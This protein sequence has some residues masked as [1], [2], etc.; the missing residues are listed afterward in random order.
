MHGSTVGDERL[1]GTQRRPHR[2]HH[3]S[4]FED[5]LEIGR[6][7]RAA[8]YDLTPGPKR[9]LVPPALCF[10]VEERILADGSIEAAPH[11]IPVQRLA[12]RLREEGVES[13]A[14]CLLHSYRQP[15]SEQAVAGLL[16]QVG[17][18][19]VSSE[20]CPEFREYE[21]AC[22]TALNAYVGPV[23][24]RYLQE[25]ESSCG[26]RIWI[27]QSNGGALTIGEA[28]RQAVRTILSGPAGGVD[29]RSGD[30]KKVGLLPHH[31]I[32]HGRHLHRRLPL[33]RT[34]RET[35]EAYVDGLPVR[36]PMLEIH[37]VGAGGGC[38]RDSTR[39]ASSA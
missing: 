14:I 35:H 16:R 11:K 18:L 3:H 32:R 17:F 24:Q 13:V 31:R 26:G 19:S 39:E 4:R 15:A 2:F 8:L 7:N 21:R 27:M 22:T 20:V 9:L 36:V 6:Q 28:T 33:R 25:L 30:R 10:G 5:L 37:T 38:W 23:M 12:K 1:A 34:P 29:R